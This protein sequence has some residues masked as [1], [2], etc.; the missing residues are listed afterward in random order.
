M[1]SVLLDDCK[2]CKIFSPLQVDSVHMIVASGELLLTIVNDVLDFSKLSAGHL[3]ICVQKSNLQEA[4]SVIIH[5]TNVQGASKSVKVVT[6]YDVSVPEYINTDI[7]R[8]SQ[9][10]YNLIGNAI[11]FSRPSGEVELRISICEA[12][13]DFSRHDGT[14]WYSP[15]RILNG[16]LLP[17]LRG[18]VIRLAVKDCGQGIVAED[19]EKIFLPFLQADQRVEC[20]DSGTGLGLS[21][22]TNLV[23]ALGGS[24]FVAS[25]KGERTTFTIDLPFSD[26]PADKNAL[27]IR[28]AKSTIML[29]GCEP[30][31]SEQ[32]CAVL[33]SLGVKYLC[34][35]TLPDVHDNALADS[36]GQLGNDHSYIFLVHEDIYDRDAYDVLSRHRNATILTYGPGL[37]VKETHQ[38][39]RSLTELLPSV[40]LTALAQH[41]E[42]QKPG[43]STS[44][45]TSP[46]S[47]FG[48]SKF[49]GLRCFIAE[50]NLVNQ[51]VLGRIL[52]RLGISNIQ[53]VDNGAKA[54]E[55]EASEPF[56][57]I[58][59]DFQM[60][61]MSGVAA[62]R[63]ITS[64]SEQ[65]SHPPAKVIFVT[66][67]ALD[68][69][70]QEAID[71]GAA[72]FL[73]KPCSME[74]VEE[75]LKNL[76]V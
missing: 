62:T 39:F 55:L 7:R 42:T 29:V 49:H 36:V 14:T 12:D 45:R 68:A 5:A 34:R 53:I 43:E 60:P 52:S 25:V 18:P 16:E 64:R 24:I 32:M 13:D 47:N 44:T 56:D 57:I 48:E 21:I 70:E 11:K 73:A 46:S 30:N 51:K 35:Q 9:I 75:I 4:L 66:A 59:M 20:L 31:E 22:T 26:L 27:A 72:G 71:A 28:L 40:F 58:F 33:R 17:P 76:S 65:G 61:I 41:A 6:K 63:L 8:L 2:H 15:P 23:H 50:D 19:Y 38:H 69:H 10:L 3:D 67:H 1:A 54:V 37:K 74:R